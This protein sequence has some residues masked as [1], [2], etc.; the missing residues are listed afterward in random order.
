V[1]QRGYDNGGQSSGCEG[2]RVQADWFGDPDVG[3]HRWAGTQYGNPLT[4]ASMRHSTLALMGRETKSRRPLDA[5]TSQDARG[6]WRAG[7]H[8]D[9]LQLSGLWKQ[10]Q[11]EG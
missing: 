4:A 7:A 1:L 3:S 2:V 6:L 9:R 5:S 10:V 11:R 8:V